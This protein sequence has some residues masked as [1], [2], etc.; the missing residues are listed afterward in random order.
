MQLLIC[1]SSNKFSGCLSFQE[2][3]NLSVLSGKALFSFLFPYSSGYFTNKVSLSA[4]ECK[5]FISIL[6]QGKNLPSF[7]G[8]IFPGAQHGTRIRLFR[9]ETCSL[10]QLRGDVTRQVC[11]PSSGNAPR[12]LTFGSPCL[13]MNMDQPLPPHQA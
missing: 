13:C 5:L 3:P 12:E 9:L 6:S 2:A 7:C 11:L 10:T 4:T 1:S 8:N